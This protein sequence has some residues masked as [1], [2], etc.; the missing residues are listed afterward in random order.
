MRLLTLA[1]SALLVFTSAAYAQGTPDGETPANEGVC[2]ELRGF[3]SLYGLCVAFCEAQDCEAT[4]DA[5][6]GEV[7]FVG[8]CMKHSPGTLAV[9]NKLA[10]PGDP[11]MPCVEVVGPEC[12]CFSSADLDL[13]VNEC[14]T[15]PRFEDTIRCRSSL[16]STQTICSGFGGGEDIFFQAL[17]FFG[18]NTACNFVDT[19][20]PAFPPAT[21]ITI[22]L[23]DLTIEEARACIQLQ[24]DK[25]EEPGV[26]DVG[27]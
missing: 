21:E 26:C 5:V 9:Y 11:A 27:P 22:S 19:R 20:D 8:N 16:V 25:Q 2:D 6:T 10:Q 4:I 18:V 12:P 15:D 1:T 17:S 13:L 14:R 3:A 7:I 23:N 24:I